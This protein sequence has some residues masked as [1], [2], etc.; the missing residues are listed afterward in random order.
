[1]V[2][3]GFRDLDREYVVRV[4]AL[5]RGRFELGLVKYTYHHMFGMR[6][7]EGSWDEGLRLTIL[8]RYRV[9]RRGVG[10]VKPSLVTPRVTP[11]RLG[12]HSTDFIEVREYAPGDPFK[13]IN[14]KASARSTQGKLLSNEYERE[15]LRTV[16][17]L[18]DVSENMR[19]GL[20]HE[21]PL[22]YSIYLILSLAKALIR[23]GYNVGLW[24]L[25]ATPCGLLNRGLRLLLRPCP[26]PCTYPHHPGI[27]NSS[28]YARTA[29]RLCWLGV[30]VL[31]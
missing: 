18:V 8:P 1:V 16:V 4:K 19:Y 22:E 10:R 29:R 28:T 5:R 30:S 6:V 26:S 17:F 15:G 27:G 24:T 11:I 21:N 13:F 2:F 12:P 23:Y 7:I 3:K 9:I 31:A 20:P 25:P 14:W